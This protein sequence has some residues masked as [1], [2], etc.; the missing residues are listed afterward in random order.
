MTITKSRMFHGSLRYAPLLKIRPNPRILRHI[1]M[2]YKIW[3]A[4]SE[5][6][7]ICDYS[8]W[9]GSSMAKVTQFRRIVTM[10]IVSKAALL[11]MASATIVI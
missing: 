1:S 2:V 10:D 8:V 5:R 7:S 4:H 9:V 3:N 6:M 11:M